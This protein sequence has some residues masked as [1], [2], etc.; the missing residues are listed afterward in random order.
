MDLFYNTLFLCFYGRSFMDLFYCTLFLFFFMV[1]PILFL[2]FLN[3]MAVI[4]ISWH[5]GKKMALYRFGGAGRTR[6]LSSCSQKRMVK[7]SSDGRQ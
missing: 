4:F 6:L 5:H 3:F 1:H 2:I 7:C